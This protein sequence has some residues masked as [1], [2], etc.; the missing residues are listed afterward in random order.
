VCRKITLY[1]HTL[2]ERMMNIDLDALSTAL[3]LGVVVET[4]PIGTRLVFVCESLSGVTLV[5]GSVMYSTGKRRRLRVQA[6]G[7]QYFVPLGAV[8]EVLSLPSGWSGD[9]ISLL[10]GVSTTARRG[11]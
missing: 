5:E 1:D 6:G 9:P 10:G 11:A 7:C 8:A 3:R 4:L 2:P